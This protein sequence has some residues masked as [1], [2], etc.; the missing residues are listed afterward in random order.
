M[1][2]AWTEQ[3]EKAHPL[4]FPSPEPCVCYSEPLEDQG[5]DYSF[6]SQ[7]RWGLSLPNLTCFCSSRLEASFASSPHRE[8]VLGC[9]TT[10][11]TTQY[12][13]S[14]YLSSSR[15]LHC[16]LIVPHNL[17]TC[18]RSLLSWV[19]FAPMTPLSTLRLPDAGVP[20]SWRSRQLCQSLGSL[21]G[22]TVSPGRLWPLYLDFYLSLAFPA[23]GHNVC[24]TGHNSLLLPEKRK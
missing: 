24:L 9:Q 17:A 2:Q 4:L 23:D 8:F 11:V 16:L 3:K 22:C 5:R 18:S 14:V 6:C 15:I 21:F 10:C 12:H 13:T 19:Y 20:H 1:C 7:Q